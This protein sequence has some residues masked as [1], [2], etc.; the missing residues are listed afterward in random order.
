MR[1]TPRF[2]GTTGWLVQDNG[3]AERLNPQALQRVGKS[4]PKTDVQGLSGPASR[5]SP[6]DPA[7]S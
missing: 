5:V 4:R 1:N 6:R 7:A 2:A 3:P